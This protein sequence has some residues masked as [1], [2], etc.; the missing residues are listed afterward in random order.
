MIARCFGRR[1]CIVGLKFR[2]Y[3]TLENWWRCNWC[4]GHI[5]H[6]FTQD[7]D[8]AHCAD[9]GSENFIPGWLFDKQVAEGPGI[10][11][12]LPP[13]IQALFKSVEPVSA[14]QAIDEL[15]N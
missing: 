12:T 14:T 13:D 2:T 9:C 5:V 7:R 11:E 15:F 8:W 4:G 10:V 3:S 6:H 1:G